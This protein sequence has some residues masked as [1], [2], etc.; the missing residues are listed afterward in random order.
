MTDKTKIDDFSKTKVVV[1]GAGMAG[2][3]AASKLVNSGV[4][5]VVVLEAQDYIGGRIKTQHTV[6]KFVLSRFSY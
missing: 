5:D 6:G 2:L 1:V 3:T 4:T